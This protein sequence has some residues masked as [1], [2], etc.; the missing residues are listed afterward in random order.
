M[1]FERNQKYLQDEI[2]RTYNRIQYDRT[3]DETHISGLRKALVELE[4]DLENL[5]VSV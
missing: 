2:Q 5:S 1:I 4:N 3:L